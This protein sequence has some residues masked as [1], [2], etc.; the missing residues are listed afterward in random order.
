MAP[1]RPFELHA[2]YIETADPDDIANGTAANK[3]VK[4]DTAGHIPEGLFSS[5][6]Q[7]KVRTLNGIVGDINL[8]G[9]GLIKIKRS[10]I[11]PQTVVLSAAAPNYFPTADVRYVDSQ[12]LQ[13]L[14]TW[15]NISKFTFGA[16]YSFNANVI[17]TAK[18]ITN[19]NS[20]SARLTISNPSSGVFTAYQINNLFSD[21]LSIAYNFLKVPD[22]P[23][24]TVSLDV[25]FSNVSGSPT[26]S[27]TI[28]NCATNLLVLPA[29]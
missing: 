1:K 22:G 19:N 5:E 3:I 13:T 28:A 14:N 7:T 11:D 4:T 9:G 21:M 27:V 26:P 15:I 23:S 16:S 6:H 12:T 2:D 25:E 8:V 24:Y 29:I 17:S 20:Y 18:V 10:E